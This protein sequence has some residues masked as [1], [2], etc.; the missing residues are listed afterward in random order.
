MSCF[1][2]YLA[3][4][5]NFKQP[6]ILNFKNGFWLKEKGRFVII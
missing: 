1:C 6:F 5:I 2:N 4:F 3:Y